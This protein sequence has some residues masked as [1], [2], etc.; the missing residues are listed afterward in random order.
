MT[1]MVLQAP[2][3]VLVEMVVSA[4]SMGQVASVVLRIFS[5]VSSAEAVLRAI[6][7]L[8]AKEMISS[9]VSI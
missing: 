7:T 5:Q 8:L 2:M 3:V 1:S 9:I 6:Q 4:V